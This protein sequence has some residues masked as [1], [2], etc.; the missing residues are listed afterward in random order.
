M[1]EET[2]EKEVP[3]IDFSPLDFFKRN[4]N[5]VEKKHKTYDKYSSEMFLDGIEIDTHK[6]EMDFYLN[7]MNHNSET[8]INNMI[9]KIKEKNIFGNKSARNAINF[10]ELIVTEKK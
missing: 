8:K 10:E 9:K 2:H 5:A 6:M 4:T 1:I 3:H 7:H